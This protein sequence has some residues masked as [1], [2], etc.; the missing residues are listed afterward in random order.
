MDVPKSGGANSESIGT[1]LNRIGGVQE[2]SLYTTGTEKSLDKDQFLRMF[3]EQL[4]FQDPMNPVKNEQFSQ[5]MAMFS[6]LEQQMNMNKNIE[7]LVNQQNNTQIAALQLVGKDITA[8]RAAIYHEQN[9]VSPM[10]FKLPYDASE[11]KVEIKDLNGNTVRTMTLGAQ[12]QGEVKSKWDGLDDIGKPAA[13]GKYSYEIKVQNMENKEEKINTKVDGRV[14]G[15]TTAAGVVFLLVGDQKIALNDVE[16]IKEASAANAVKVADA[17]A[18][19]PGESPKPAEASAPSAPAP[20][21]IAMNDAVKQAL[22]GAS[23]PKPAAEAQEN[24][25]QNN[26]QDEAILHPLLPLMYR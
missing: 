7:K 26:G 4:K 19:A 6:Q 21:Q 17:S 12:T 2:K 24:N 20:T 3:M 13:P 8:D 10:Q 5:Q 15:V 25:S 9:K 14:T 22:A 18:S 1:Q 23:E 11:V 16:M